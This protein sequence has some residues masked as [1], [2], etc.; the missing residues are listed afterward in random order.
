MIHPEFESEEGGPL[1]E[2]ETVPPIGTAGM[3]ILVDEMRS[4]HRE[5]IRVR[6]RGFMMGGPD[7]L[8]EVEVIE[9]VSLSSD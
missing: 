2:A 8:A 3:W 6:V 1:S 7:R 5:R 4:Y 9:V